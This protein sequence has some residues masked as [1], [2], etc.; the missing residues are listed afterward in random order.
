MSGDFYAIGA[1]LDLLCDAARAVARR[2]AAAT[3]GAGSVQRKVRVGWVKAKR[4][5][6]LLERYGVI[7]PAPGGCG[8]YDCGKHPVLITEAQVPE[9]ITR[10]RKIASNERA[11][12]GQGG[13]R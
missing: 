13:A 6:I 3:T 9:T 11:P 12:V 7:G 1:D 4:L 8:A 5:V 2:R 10:L